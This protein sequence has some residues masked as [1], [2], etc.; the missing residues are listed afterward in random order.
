MV[1][2]ESDSDRF[3]HLDETLFNDV[4]FDETGDIVIYSYTHELVKLIRR[5]YNFDK[6]SQMF[7]RVGNQTVNRLTLFIHR[8]SRLGLLTEAQV[9][10]WKHSANKYDTLEKMLSKP[11][12]STPEN[13]KL[14]LEIIKKIKAVYGD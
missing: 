1:V 14:K 8:F 2:E 12:N 9:E 6:M 11:I 5:K 10:K 13:E 4:V 3:S 7:V